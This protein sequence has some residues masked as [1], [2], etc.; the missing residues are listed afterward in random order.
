MG[1][2]CH[3][4]PF[5]LSLL[6]SL[7]RHSSDLLTSGC[8][9]PKEGEKHLKVLGNKQLSKPASVAAGCLLVAIGQFSVL[10]IFSLI[11]SDK[12]SQNA[13]SEPL[14]GSEKP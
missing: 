10:V 12:Y 13:F 6:L 14:G 5:A 11:T 2:E 1:R 8:P 7:V 9:S 3:K 4:G